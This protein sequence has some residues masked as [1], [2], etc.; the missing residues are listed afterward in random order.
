MNNMNV[1]RYKNGD[2]RARR[3]FSVGVTKRGLNALQK[4]RKMS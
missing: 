3:I 2:S 4:R 1:H